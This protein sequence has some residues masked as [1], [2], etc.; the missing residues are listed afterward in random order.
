M[1]VI[2]IQI[3]ASIFA[4]IFQSVL[5]APVYQDFTS[6]MEHGAEILMN[7]MTSMFHALVHRNALIELA[8]MNVAV[9]MAMN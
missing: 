8:H 6:M 1:N 4:L 5:N 9:T 7:A 2:L 3:H